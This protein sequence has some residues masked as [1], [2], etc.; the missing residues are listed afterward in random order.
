M[1]S[2][3]TYPDVV[4]LA[5][6]WAGTAVA[7]TTGDAAFLQAMLDA[8]AALTR[9]QAGLGQAHSSAAD[10]VA[11]AARADRFDVGDLAVRA[12]A[13]G[14]PVIPLVA[15]LTAAVPAD[16]AP[17]VHRGATSQDVLDTA[18]MLVASRAVAGILDD[19]LHAADSLARLAAEHRLTPMPGRT[20]TQHAVPITF[21]L[22][23]AGWRSLVLDGA[24]RLAALRPPAQLGGAAG[25]LD[26]FAERDGAPE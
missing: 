11:A 9:A 17:F 18:L 14:N 1:T 21:G 20:L 22:K 13:G 12:R 23:A 26:E 2:S 5:P 25:K 7:E 6:V 3:E 8:E 4:L 19:L 15:D 16:A 10:A 24:D